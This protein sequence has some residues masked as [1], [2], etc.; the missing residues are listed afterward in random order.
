MKVS[1]YKN[2]FSNIGYTISI[3]DALN[4]VKNGKSKERIDQLRQCT[5]QTEADEI[6]K[7]LP[8]VTYSGVFYPTRTDGNHKEKSGFIVLD[9]DKLDSVAD[10]KA[11]LM[12]WE[13]CYAAWISPSGTGI[14][15]LVKIQDPDKHRDHFRAIQER[16]PTV[17]RTG[18]NP[19][20]LCFESYDPDIYINSSAKVYSELYVS[21]FQQSVNN[22]N[23]EDSHFQK[24]VTWLASRGDGFRTGERNSYIYKL[25][26]ACCRLG[27]DK[28][29]V[30]SMCRGYATG[31]F[32]IKECDKAV[33]SAYK[34]NVFGSAEFKDDR[35]ND[36]ATKKEVVLQNLSSEEEEMMQRD[37]VHLAD[38]ETSIDDSYYNGLPNVL[39]IG[40]PE[41]DALFK[42]NRTE[43]TVITGY[44]NQGKSAFAKWYYFMRALKYKEKTAIF[45][46]E[47][48]A[49]K[50]FRD[51][52]GTY[53][54]V[55]IPK[56]HN[57]LLI[58]KYDEAKKFVSDHFLY[59]DSKV[60]SPT[61]TYIKSLF[62]RTIMLHGVSTV[63]IDPFN[64]L[65]NDYRQSGGRSD[66]YLE[67]FLSD[68]KSFAKVN[69]VH[70][71]IVAHPR[72]PHPSSK[73][74]SGN[75]PIPTMYDLADGAMW[76][77]KAD[78]ILVYYRPFSTDENSE[79][80]LTTRKI[81]DQET[82]GKIGQMSLRY[83]YLKK[84]FFIQRG[85][86][87]FDPIQ[88][89]FDNQNKE[90]QIEFNAPLP[91]ALTPN[92]DFLTNTFGQPKSDHP[93]DVNQ[94]LF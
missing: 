50:F 63:V 58:S 61:P 1:I 55:Y 54:G 7:S 25:A 15:A 47:E 72:N 19:S 24:I 17:D 79:C 29:Y 62:L 45:A 65:S 8:A 73:D 20:R 71:H 42:M 81:K 60:V 12:A 76:A 69:N 90:V 21:P 28:G 88:E 78:N 56:S 67:T 87:L 36:R 16:W 94:D 83:N 80:S 13:Y 48:T 92:T 52:I 40:V 6:K 34:G 57:R 27:L 46:P 3:E 85:T 5:S 74:A 82:V 35:V 23:A 70:T 93:S 10:K 68:I 39:G 2:A 64:Q 53:C 32:T 9:F 75:F 37:I 49:E 51:M 31:T 22:L 84:R 89:I 26:S 66:K 11:D 91:A 59:I 77:N 18:I 41:I 43:L 86:Q 44:A 4:R 30:L 38:V 33:E 14:K